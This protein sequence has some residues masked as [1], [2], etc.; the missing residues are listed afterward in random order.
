MTK[1]LDELLDDLRIVHAEK[2]KNKPY[3]LMGSQ[4]AHIHS[5][6]SE[7]FENIRAMHALEVQTPIMG[8]KADEM[9]EFLDEQWD[10]IYSAI[11]SM[12][13]LSATNEQIIEG[14]E[15]C[16]TK[17]QNRAFKGL[18]PDLGRSK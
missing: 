18:P 5:E 1:G 9:A 4:L 15:K 10:I 11:T 12:F 17:I 16:L 2:H 8:F 3:Q 14:M 13:L 6:V 7:L